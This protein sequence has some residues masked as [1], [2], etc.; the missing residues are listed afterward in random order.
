MYF[1]CLLQ[2]SVQFNK[3][4][5]TQFVCNEQLNAIQNG[6]DLVISVEKAE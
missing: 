6:L 3:W 4:I 2:G 1:R 5:K